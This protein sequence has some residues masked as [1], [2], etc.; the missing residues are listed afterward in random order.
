MKPTLKDISGIFNCSEEQVRDQ[1]RKNAIQLRLCAVKAVGGNGT[2]RGLSKEEW[3]KR[4]LYAERM[5]K[6]EKNEFE[7]RHPVFMRRCVQALNR[8]GTFKAWINGAWVTCNRARLTSENGFQVRF[9]LPCG[10]NQWLETERME[11]KSIFDEPFY[12]SR[13]F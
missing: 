13:E 7:D 11:F 10:K 4:A 1:F 12:V 6:G 9:E 2:Y 8:A 3:I 5:A